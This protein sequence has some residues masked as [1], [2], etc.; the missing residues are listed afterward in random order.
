M[1]ATYHYLANCRVGLT[2]LV[3][4]FEDVAY[5]LHHCLPKDTHLALNSKGGSSSSLAGQEVKLCN[6]IIINVFEHLF[7]TVNRVTSITDGGQCTCVE[8]LELIQ[9][10]SLW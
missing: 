5:V 4:Y 2:Y 6:K 7:A 8:N 10:S 3:S 1:E 9:N